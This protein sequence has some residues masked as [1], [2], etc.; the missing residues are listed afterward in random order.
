[1]KIILCILFMFVGVGSLVFNLV[2]NNVRPEGI[3]VVLYYI[4]IFS[5]YL[6]GY[7]INS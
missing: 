2:R 4:T 5:L 6:A 3:N 7:F 1:M